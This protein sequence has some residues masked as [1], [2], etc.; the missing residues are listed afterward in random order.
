MNGSYQRSCWFL[1]LSLSSC[2]VASMQ[3]EQPQG[4]TLFD[5]IPARTVLKVEDTRELRRHYDEVILLTCLQGI[6][7]RLQPRI[8]VRYNQAPDDYWMG[9][10]TNSP[11]AWLSGKAIV[12]ATDVL[13]VVQDYAGAVKGLILWDEQVPAT[14]NVAMSVAGVEDCLVVRYDR[15]PD[16]LCQ[17]LIKGEKGFPIRQSFVHKDGSSVFTGQG[18]IEGAGRASTGSQKNDAYIWLL[19]TY[20]KTG[21]LNPSMLGYYL[22]GFWLKCHHVSALQNHTVN[23]MDYLIAHRAPILD[24]NVWDDEVPVDDPHQVPGTDLKTLREFL[25]C[26]V[27]RLENRSMIAVYGFP[28]WA[29]KYTNFKTGGWEAKGR[30]EPVATEWTFASIMS[31]YNAYM[32]GDALGYSSLPNASFYEHYKP[33][34]TLSN[35]PSPTRESLIRAGVLDASG[36]LRAINYYAIY[37]GDYD[38]A[39][40]V[41]WHFPRVLEDPKRGKVPLTW[42]INPTLAQRF[43]FGLCHIRATRAEQEVFIAGEGAGYLNPSLLQAPRPFPGLPDAMEVWIR[44]NQ[45]WYDAW[46]LTVTGFNIDGYAPPLNEQG[47]AAY[48]RFSP[49]GIGLSHAPS[50]YGVVQG[51][52]YVQMMTDL[53]SNDLRP[54]DEQTVKQVSL[55]FE[56]DM[57]HFVLVRSILQTPSYYAALQQRLSGPD[58]LP[59][60]CVDLPTLLWLIK[61]WQQDPENMENDSP[62]AQPPFVRAS[63]DTRFGLRRRKSGDGCGMVEREASVGAWIVSQEPHAKYLYFDLSGPFARASSG[64]NV[65]IRVTTGPLADPDAQVCLQYDSLEKNAPYKKAVLREKKHEA[66]NI[67]WLFEAERADF[68]GRQN[69]GADFRLFI[70][71]GKVRILTV[72]CALKEDPPSK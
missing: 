37:Q 4:I 67:C 29:Y 49:G 53:S 62:L 30:H 59:N 52:P 14:L 22:D 6:A 27:D 48:R 15:A 42:A 36:K 38:G 60:K 13:S 24:L 25:K 50:P 9:K 28:P 71:H 39:A 1:V 44:H 18:V 55:L 23:N 31:A 66:Q 70:T 12:R 64:S 21:K 68:K 46:D 41:Y 54:L 47:I 32:D 5:C 19:E 69:S 26:A 35:A 3:A 2:W 11:T 34:G 57:P 65:W 17:Q 10:M 51:M 8:F 56:E 16:S 33:T 63:P 58:V 7:N 43:M 45:E 72:A 20:M 61:A 40:W